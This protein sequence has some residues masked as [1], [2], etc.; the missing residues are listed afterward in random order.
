MTSGPHR[1]RRRVSARGYEPGVLSVAERE[2]GLAFAAADA[3]DLAAEWAA[4][5]VPE[6]AGT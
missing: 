6:R 2:A 3:A 1:R 5:S 4:M